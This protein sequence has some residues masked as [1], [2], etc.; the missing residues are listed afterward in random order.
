[1]DY[2]AE[3]DTAISRFEQFSERE[4]SRDLGGLVSPPARKRGTAA[5]ARRLTNAGIAIALLIAATVAFALIIGP[6]GLSGLVLVAALMLALLLAI[7]FWP[8]PAARPVAPYKEDMPNRAVVQ[9]LGSLLTRHRAQ[10]PPAAGQKVDAIAGQLPM[11]ESQLAELNPLD[12]LAQDARRLMGQHLPEL[13]ERYERVPAQFRRERDGDGMSVDER[14]V[15]GLDAAREAIGDL[16]RRLS[17]QDV[18]AFETQ[19][20]FIE[21]RYRDDGLGAER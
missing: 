10:L 15:S 9:R 1:M 20:R 19:G 7:S 3:M 18:D 6:I 17:E 14:L 12:P 13:I 4:G 21:S 2:R 16:G 11:L 8:S 5:I